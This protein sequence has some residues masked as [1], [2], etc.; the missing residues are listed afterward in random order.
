MKLPQP[1]TGPLFTAQ[2]VRGIELTY[3][4][5]SDQGTFPLMEKAGQ[6]AFDCLLQYWPDARKILVLSGKGNNGGD[7]YIVAALAKSAGFE[8]TLCCF[9]EPEKLQGDAKIAYEQ[10]QKFD[11]ARADWSEI[12]LNDYQVLV[13]AML[14]TG[15]SGAVRAPFIEPIE[16]I[17][18]HEIP[19]LS[20]DIPSGLNANTGEVVNCAIKA[21]I[22]M[23]YIG[24][25]QGLYTGD[26]ADFRGKVLVD[27]LDISTQC[28]TAYESEVQAENWFTLNHR[29]APRLPSAHKGANGHCVI[30]GGANGY[31]GAAILVS[32]AAARC[33]AGLTSTWLEGGALALV[34]TFPEVMAKNIPEHEVMSQVNELSVH[35]VL[36]I[37]PGLGK[38]NW[39]QSWMS[40][41]TKHDGFDS[42]M[43]VIDADGLNWLAQNHLTNE[44]WVLTPHPGEASRLLNKK[45]NAI[46]ADRYAAAREIAKKY[47]GVCVLKGAGTVIADQSGKTIVCPVGN[48]GMGT[49]G[50]GDVLSGIVGGLLAQGISLFEAATLAV[51]I[52]GEAADRAAG[53]NANYRGLI[54]S[55]LFAYLPQLVNPPISEKC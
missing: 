3:A 35:H 45:V 25:K 9:C 30:I 17:N 40:A 11:I 19:V 23:T 20:I 1:P 38:K 33:G 5:T 24:L 14:G 13:D 39:G 22:T 18:R 6:A 2:Q 4:E 34:S 27:G 48:P 8:V 47:G 42:M 15:I 44:K 37:G 16:S 28:F 55:D 54:A 32:K 26:A 10:L 36:V 12:D 51:V 43:K 53:E 31:T 52:H 46:N 50:M 49:G 41:V 7:G 21:Q 29:L